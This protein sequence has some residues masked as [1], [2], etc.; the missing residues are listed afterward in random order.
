MDENDQVF[1]FSDQGAPPLSPEPSMPAAR[2]VARRISVSTL[3][4]WDEYAAWERALLTDTFQDNPRLW[5]LADGLAAQGKTPREKLDKIFAWVQQSI[6]Y[7]Q[8]YETTIAGVRPHPATTVIERGYGDCKDK[9]SLLIQL[10]KRAGLQLRLALLRVSGTGKVE[11]S[12]PYPQFDHAIVYVPVQK[13]I[14]APFFLDPTTDGLD[15]ENLRADDQGADSLVLDPSTGR[16]EFIT[17]PY[18]EPEFDHTVQ[19]I[20]IEVHSSTEA[21]VFREMQLRG[22]KAREARMSLRNKE[23]AQQS[24]E[25]EAQ[26]FLRGAMLTKWTTSDRDDLWHPLRLEM[27][28]NAD[29][30]IQPEGDHWRLG[31]PE[32]FRMG[33]L[34][35]LNERKFPLRLGIKRSEHVDIQ[36]TIPEGY[37]IVHIPQSVSVEHPCLSAN[38]RVKLASGCVPMLVFRG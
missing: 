31:L 33:D 36:L 10:A 22:K 26:V 7:Q 32:F 15:I 37:K 34:V 20:R 16:Y 9:A 1:I 14:D 35:A 29:A 5:E 12:I 2:D 24:F 23:G 30:A 6:R 3:P 28:Y 8:D 13:E 17:I 21:A 27:D 4:N 25:K 19:N 18:Q 38:S 11:R